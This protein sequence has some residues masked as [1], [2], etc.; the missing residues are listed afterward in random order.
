MLPFADLSLYLAALSASYLLP[1][2][3]M[4]LVIGTATGRGM[5]AGLQAALG[6]AVSRSLHVLASGLGLSAAFAAHPAL[7][8]AVRW[9]GAAYLLWLAGR[10]ACAGPDAAGADAAEGAGRQGGRSAVVQGLL[11]NLLNPKAFM[12]CALFLPQFV[13]PG[14]G[15]PLGQ[16]ALLGA[17]LVVVGLAYDALYALA[18]SAAIR[19]IGGRWQGRRG[20]RLAFSAVFAALAVRLAVA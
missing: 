10:I 8:D 15:D 20:P 2:P 14:R 18:A 19:R 5:R 11:T 9:L 1:G 7:F 16:Y 4:A 17:I 6:L 12:F 3:D 13:A